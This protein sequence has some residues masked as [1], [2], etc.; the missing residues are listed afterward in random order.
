MAQNDR[1]QG[2]ATQVALLLG[3]VVLTVATK[4]ILPDPT[5][6]EMMSDWITFTVDIVSTVIIASG[7]YLGLD[8]LL[9]R[10]DASV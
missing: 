8:H 2:R 4:M 9:S 1:Q 7:Y 10:G 5:L 6:E 3:V